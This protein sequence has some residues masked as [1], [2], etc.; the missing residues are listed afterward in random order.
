[1]QKDIIINT[2]NNYFKYKS[3]K[4][5]EYSVE[6][7]K[8]NVPFI[9]GIGKGNESLVS[10]NE[11]DIVLQIK[12]LADKLQDGAIKKVIELLDEYLK[13]IKS[14]Y[15][16]S[17]NKTQFVEKDSILIGDLINYYI[18][19]NKTTPKTELLSLK[20]NYTLLIIGI[21]AFFE[22]Y[23]FPEKFTNKN[24]INLH[25]IINK[26]LD[27][28]KFIELS[29]DIDK[30]FE[31]LE[32]SMTKISV[33][34]DKD[35]NLQMINYFDCPFEYTKNSLLIKQLILDQR[36]INCQNCGSTVISRRSHQRF[37]S[38]K[39]RATWSRNK[40]KKMR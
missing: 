25:E 2:T 39:C 18:N 28:Y 16:I 32:I 3:I 1:M 40:N 13:K 12:E 34:K 7:D 9:V 38:N 4:F 11:E 14:E 37:C 29:K 24:K 15:F 27:V 10:T 36:L 6:Y 22:T 35:G 20:P 21:T 19:Q 17:G 33:I 23:G 5:E 30:N 26:I 8:Y 31:K